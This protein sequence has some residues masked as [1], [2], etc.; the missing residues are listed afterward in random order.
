MAPTQGVN[1]S[2]DSFEVHVLH[3]RWY[4]KQQNY[5]FADIYD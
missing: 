3:K 5:G 1:T 4:S 2:I